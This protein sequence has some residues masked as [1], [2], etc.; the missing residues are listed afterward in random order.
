MVVLKNT[1][2]NSRQTVH[3]DRLLPCNLPISTRSETDLG[4]LPDVLTPTD[5]QQSQDNQQGDE[6]ESQSQS[7]PDSSRPTRTRRLPAALEP[8]ILG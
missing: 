5:Q 8:Y 7:V 4:G 2:K 3:V 6:S 1:V